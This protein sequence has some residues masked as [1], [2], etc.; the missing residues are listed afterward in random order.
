MRH[1]MLTSHHFTTASRIPET[2]MA[3]TLNHLQL[4]ALLLTIASASVTMFEAPLPL[5][6]IKRS[7]VVLYKK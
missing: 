6:D 3:E 7:Q 1:W 5:G 4:T 2:C